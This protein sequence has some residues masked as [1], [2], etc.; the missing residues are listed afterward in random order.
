MPEN[1][2][3]I[4]TPKRRVKKSR[5][6]ELK[7]VNDEYE[8]ILDIWGPYGNDQKTRKIKAREILQRNP[9]LSQF[10][11]ALTTQPTATDS[12]EC[13]EKLCAKFYH[14]CTQARLLFPGC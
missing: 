4:Y 2:E 5:Y 3:Q 13:D 12:E 10:R 7:K 8:L 6:L 1:K 11:T 9:D 14:E